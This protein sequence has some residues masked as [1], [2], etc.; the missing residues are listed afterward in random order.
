MNRQLRQHPAVGHKTPTEQKRRTV[1]RR[2]ALHHSDGTAQIIEA[3]LEV[4]SGL[5]VTFHLYNM[6]EISNGG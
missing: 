4:I 6:G 3:D 1:R 5:D 2:F